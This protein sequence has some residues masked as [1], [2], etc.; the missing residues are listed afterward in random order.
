MVVCAGHVLRGNKASHHH[1]GATHH[2]VT[3]KDRP[4][5]CSLCC[6]D[7]VKIVRASGPRPSLPQQRRPRRR[8]RRPPPPLPSATARGATTARP[9]GPKFIS[10]KKGRWPVIVHCPA[11]VQPL[12]SDFVCATAGPRVRRPGS[13]GGQI[14]PHARVQQAMPGMQ[15]GGCRQTAKEQ[16]AAM[17]VRSPSQNGAPWVPG[18]KTW[19]G[20]WAAVGEVANVWARCTSM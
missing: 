4:P 8:A 14:K 1:G 2:A 20:S 17:T 6:R 3:V 7:T 16:V 13:G 12:S 18:G 9:A 10:M 11:T 19:G 15:A 5:A